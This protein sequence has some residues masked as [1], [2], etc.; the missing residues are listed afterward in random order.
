MAW[1]IVRQPNSL[2]A[3]FSD[4]VDNFTHLN[5]TEYEARELC[6]GYCLSEQEVRTKV[7]AGLEDWEPWTHGKKGN[8]LSRWRD[9]MRTIRA[10]H[11]GEAAQE[12]LTAIS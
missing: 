7:R 1:R 11:G 8:G 3:R 12:V 2:L 10:V 6:R 4:V 9:C 5:L